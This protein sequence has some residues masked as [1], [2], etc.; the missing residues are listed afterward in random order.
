MMS[1]GEGREAGSGKILTGLTG[2]TG[3]KAGSGE[4]EGEF[5]PYSPIHLLTFSRVD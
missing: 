3:L 5:F 2:L 1:D 4:Q